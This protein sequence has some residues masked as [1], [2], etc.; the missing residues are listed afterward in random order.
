MIEQAY[1]ANPKQPRWEGQEHFMGIG[2]S[3]MATM[4]GLRAHAAQ[5]LSSEALLA[6]EARKAREEAALAAKQRS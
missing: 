3:G 1:A 4:P 2:R 6:K 5:G